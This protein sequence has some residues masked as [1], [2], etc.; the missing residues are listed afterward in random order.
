MSSKTAGDNPLASASTPTIYNVV[1]TEAGAEYPQTLPWNCRKFSIKPRVSNHV[2]KLAFEPNQTNY[3]YISFSGGG[4]WEDNI[5][6]S[7]MAVYLQCAT[8]SAVVE[9]ICWS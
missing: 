2:I 9:I 6:G 3:D 4:Y 8:P 7:G 5:N 1:L